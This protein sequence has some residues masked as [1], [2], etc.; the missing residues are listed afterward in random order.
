MRI[1]K[2]PEP[3]SLHG[4]A[5]TLDT[6]CSPTG[7]GRIILRLRPCRRPLCQWGDWWFADWK[8]LQA[9]KDL[10]DRKHVECKNTW[11]LFPG[12]FAFKSTNVCSC[13]RSWDVILDDLGVLG[14]HFETILV[15]MC[16]RVRSGEP[17][18]VPGLMFFMIFN[19]F[20]DTYWG[21]FWIL[22]LMFLWFGVSKSRLGLLSWALMTF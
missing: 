21:H 5:F 14:D 3:R 17:T 11:S 1:V 4:L 8:D 19:G 2:K 10:L 12:R 22:F 20:G 7:W 18:K 6:P 16:A 13:W 9:L 15:I